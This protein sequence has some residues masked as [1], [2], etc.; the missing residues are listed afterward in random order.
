MFKCSDSEENIGDWSDEIEKEIGEV[1][2]RV[3][4]INEHLASL[5]LEQ[6]TKTQESENKIKARD[7]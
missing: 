2:T 3:T 7:R 6:D 5:K 1:N 4:Y